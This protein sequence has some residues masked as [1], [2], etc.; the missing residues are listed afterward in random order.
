[1]TMLLAAWAVYLVVLPLFAWSQLWCTNVYFDAN[2]GQVKQERYLFYMKAGETIKD[3]D[4]SRL[5]LKHMGQPRAR[6]WKL[7]CTLSPG[8]HNSPHYIY[9]GAMSDARMFAKW[10]AVG[11]FTDEAKA[12]AARDF[13]SLYK[14]PKRW[15]KATFEYANAIFELALQSDDSGKEVTVAALPA[16]EDYR[17][18]EAL[19]PTREAANQR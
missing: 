15:E 18:Q 2:S 19:P 11:K 5:Y 14:D 9:H 1:M 10:L 6:D 7:D 16:I 8:V 4:F 17:A 3:T 12:E 13:L